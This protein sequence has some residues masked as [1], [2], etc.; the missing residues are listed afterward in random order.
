[1]RAF[2]VRMLHLRNQSVLITFHQE[3]TGIC[4][5]QL[6]LYSDMETPSGR[7][8]S[9]LSLQIPQL[10]FSTY[11]PHKGSTKWLMKRQ[12]R[13]APMSQPL[14]LR[15]TSCCMHRRWGS[16]TD[17]RC[18]TEPSINT[19]GEARMLLCVNRLH[20]PPFPSLVPQDM[21][22]WEQFSDCLLVSCLLVQHWNLL[23]TS[24]FQWYWGEMVES[25]LQS[26]FMGVF[27]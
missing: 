18:L 1:M 27:C 11:G 26:I 17:G 7:A 25:D 6:T 21:F 4:M 10:G 14:S 2:Q 3:S 23:P 15:T 12:R 13:P 24:C 22:G 19:E 5:A 8:G 9:S 20:F 16:L